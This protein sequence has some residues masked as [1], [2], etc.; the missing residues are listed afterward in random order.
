M[1][2][3]SDLRGIIDKFFSFGK[4]ANENAKGWESRR[5]KIYF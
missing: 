1:N 4:F 2:E 5:Q 3:T